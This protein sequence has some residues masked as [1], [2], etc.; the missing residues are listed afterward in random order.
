[1]AAQQRE[2][3]GAARAEYQAAALA[4]AT[5]AGV[6]HEDEESVVRW[7]RNASVKVPSRLMARGIEGPKIYKSATALECLIGYLHI[8][9]RR[10]RAQ[11]LI[12]WLIDGNNV[13]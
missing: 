1:M 3:N 5:R 7:G 11:E 10:A 6:L 2:V 8:N 9:G 12:E 13:K 4:A